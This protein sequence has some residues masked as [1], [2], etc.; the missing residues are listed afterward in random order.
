MLSRG[1]CMPSLIRNRLNT[2]TINRFDCFIRRFAKNITSKMIK[3]LSFADN[4]LVT[5]EL[6]TYIVCITLLIISDF[7]LSFFPHFSIYENVGVW[8][9]K[10]FVFNLFY[11]NG[12]NVAFKDSLISRRR[13]SPSF[14]GLSTSY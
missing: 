13:C 5:I 1:R 14:S 6:H 9:R 7:P 8:L 2:M 3:I 4:G 11:F 12:F 10:R